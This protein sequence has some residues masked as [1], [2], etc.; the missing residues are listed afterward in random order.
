MPETGRCPPG[1]RGLQVP[2]PSK[3][4]KV[5]IT[6]DRHKD[7]NRRRLNPTT[8]PIDFPLGSAQ[9]RAAAI[10]MLSHRAITVVDSGTLPIP[11]EHLPSHKELLR[12]WKDEGDRY[13]HELL[14]E[15]TL[16]RSA[17]LKDSNEFRHIRA[18]CGKVR[19]YQ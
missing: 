13:T 1:F 14:R 12:D 6:D 18:S 7:W 16:H 5:P 9:S 11:Y 8:D 2:A 17:I 15:N 3:T 19:R 4:V 10:A